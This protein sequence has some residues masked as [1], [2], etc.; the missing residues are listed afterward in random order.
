M[1]LDL[2]NEDYEGML[3]LE[4]FKRIYIEEN[5]GA[6]SIKFMQPDYGYYTKNYK[7]K[8]E[9]LDAFKEIKNLVTQNETDYWPC[10]F[11]TC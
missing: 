10:G 2:S 6:Y 3:N 8:Q 4:Y 7:N 11:P 5:E 1:W 9:A